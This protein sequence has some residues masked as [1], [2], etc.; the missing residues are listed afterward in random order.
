MSV[1]PDP[2][3]SRGSIALQPSYFTSSLYIQPLRQ[4]LA[5]LISLYATQIEAAVHPFELF[6]QLWTGQG[7][8]W[9][10]T[11]VHDGRARQT[12]VS[13]TE[14]VFIGTISNISSFARFSLDII[15]TEKLF[16]GVQPL[17]QAVALFALYTFHST[18]PSTSAP[19]TSYC[20]TNIAIPIGLLDL[21]YQKN[22]AH[23]YF[24]DVYK[25]LLTLPSRL[26][27]AGLSRLKP[28]V[29]HVL[30]LL[31]E[32]QT[33]HVHPDSSLKAQNP[34]QV[35]REVV[36]PEGQDVSAFLQTTGREIAEPEATTSAPAK[37]KGRPSKRDKI[38]KAKEALVSL[39]KYI[40]KNA[41][42]RAAPLLALDDEVTSPPEMAHVVFGQAP[43]T[44][45]ANYGRRKDD[46]LDAIQ[47]T[48]PSGSSRAALQRA[49]ESVLA[50]LKQIDAMAAEQ[51]LEVGGEGGDQTGLERVQRAVDE[52]QHSSGAG[53]GGGILGLLEGAGM[54][55]GTN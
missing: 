49:N 10:H 8:F 2:S 55:A 43:H 36:V 5:D 48:D 31:L 15:P 29:I 32:A 28:Y 30:D 44:S 37:K 54:E 41:V 23:M 3:A 50:R 1:A 7:W 4:D 11:R 47:S 21:I 9:L 33:F 14:R 27:E 12:F 39:E 6:K 46:L 20:A 24:L 40:N 34:S 16:N 18:Q 51:G 52:L 25:T 22:P 26:E 17:H 35:P 19:P 42:P 45:L 38:R 53:A 13:T